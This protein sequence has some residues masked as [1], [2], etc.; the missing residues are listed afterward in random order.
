MKFLQK[1]FCLLSLV[2]LIVGPV[3]ATPDLGTSGNGLTNQISEA[4][5][6]S[7]NV[8]DTSL[9]QTVGRGIKI[10]LGFVGTIFFVLTVYAGITWMTAQGN[11]EK[12][13]QAQGILRT[14]V[15]GLIIVLAAYSITTFA[16][17]FT[18]SATMGGNTTVGG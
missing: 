13:E 5:G 15:I 2:F 17:L 12:V 4:A 3:F 10:V 8:T 18:G 6:Y 11:A 9:S 1:Y 14:A 7:T 16:L